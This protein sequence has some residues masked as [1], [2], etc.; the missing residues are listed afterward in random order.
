M[1]IS[2]WQISR[3]T[4]AH[5]PSARGV[6]KVVAREPQTRAPAFRFFK[7]RQFI[8]ALALTL[9]IGSAAT[10]NLIVNGSF[11]D[12]PVPGGYEYVPGGLTTIT[13]WSTIFTGVERYDPGIYGAGS[14]SDGVLLIDLNTDDF[15]AGG[16][17][18]QTIST[19]IGQYYLLTF[20]LGTWLGYGRSGSG[21]VTASAAGTNQS[22]SVQNLNPTTAWTAQSLQFTASS[23]A[24]LV[25]FTNF[26][27]PRENFSLIDN[28]FVTESVVP[29]PSTALLLALG[30]AGLCV[31]RRQ[32]H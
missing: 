8:L 32:R 23:A 12:P 5:G 21:N 16:G 4:R 28:I 25:S 3:D 18:E 20:D 14:A 19:I 22:F 2:S 11:E 30:L 10:A 31:R 24:T 15:V 9:S 27:I 7:M 1:L 26:D 13:G 6:R 29:E 17:I